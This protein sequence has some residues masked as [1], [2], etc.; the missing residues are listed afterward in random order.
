MKRGAPLKRTTALRGADSRPKTSAPLPKKRK[1]PRRQVASKPAETGDWSTDVRKE[2]RLR[3]RGVCELGC[4]RPATEMHHRKLRRH[5]DHSAINCL[6]VCANHHR[7]IHDHVF[8][9]YQLGWLVRSTLDP[10]AV[11]V[12]R[13]HPDMG[14]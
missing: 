2:V 10:A 5:G 4:N 8:D 6:H 3:S 11:V 7:W 14:A 13:L 12:E 9:S 1:Q